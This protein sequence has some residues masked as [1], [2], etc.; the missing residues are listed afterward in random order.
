MREAREK[1]VVYSAAEEERRT[2]E[3]GLMRK[4]DFRGHE[5]RHY[6]TRKIVIIKVYFV[7]EHS[8]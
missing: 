8:Y 5:L 3:H 6:E 2:N 4:E 7:Y 1:A